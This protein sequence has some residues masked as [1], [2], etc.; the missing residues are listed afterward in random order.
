MRTF[1]W[2]TSGGDKR[3]CKRSGGNVKKEEEEK[4]MVE[5]D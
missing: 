5:R 1:R 4:G 2:T 3:I